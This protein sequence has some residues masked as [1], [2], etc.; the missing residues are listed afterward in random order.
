MH[1]VTILAVLQF[2]LFGILVGRARRQ[3]RV[4]APAT[5]GHELFERAFRVHMNTLEQ[6]VGFLP[7]LHRY[8]YLADP[9]K[10]RYEFAFTVIPTFIL[11]AAAIWSTVT[12]AAA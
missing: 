4:K 5:S 12:R 7:A 6:L 1:I 8:L 2:F 11:S 9:A 3:H 10:C